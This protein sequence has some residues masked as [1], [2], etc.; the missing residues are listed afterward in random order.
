MDPITIGAIAIGLIMAACSNTKEEGNAT[1]IPST[2]DGVSPINDAQTA[3]SIGL[4]QDIDSYAETHG[5]VSPCPTFPLKGTLKLFAKSPCSP[6]ANITDLDNTGFGICTDFNKSNMVFQFGDTGIVSSAKLSITPDQIELHANG[7]LAITGVNSATQSSG[8]LRLA[9]MNTSPTWIPFESVT[10]DQKT[11]TPNFPKGLAY[12]SG[13]LFV[14]TGNISF[15]TGKPVYSPGTVIIYSDNQT[16]AQI[17]SSLGQNPTSLSPVFIQGQHKLLLINTGNY[18]VP[19]GTP[20]NKG[21][22]III[23]PTT[24]QIT[25]SISLPR[26]GFGLSGEIAIA[27]GKAAIGSSDNSGQTALFQLS[28]LQLGATLIPSVAAP[29]GEFHFITASI[30]SDDGSFLVSGDYNTGKLKTWNISGA[31]PQEAA[32]EITL[33]PDVMDNQNIGDGF[34]KNGKLYIAVGPNIMELQ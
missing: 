5:D 29:A 27:G 24:R 32:K 22:M 30:L 28:N 2:S 17:L 3:D 21:S 18:N 1:F 19:S 25:D 6:N 9:S 26:A 33:D 11:F 23:D 10:V 12:L 16:Q 8:I 34:C 7:V 4:P 31:T 13:K 14:A 20:D 15:T